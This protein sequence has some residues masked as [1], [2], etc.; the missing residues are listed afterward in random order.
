MPELFVNPKE[1]TYPCSIYEDKSSLE[2][3]FSIFSIRSHA[4]VTLIEVVVL[5][6]CSKKR[7]ILI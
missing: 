5:I 2:I 3:E 1:I 6:I 4:D 7:P